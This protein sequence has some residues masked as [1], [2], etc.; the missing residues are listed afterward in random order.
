MQQNSV[1][2]L[3][4]ENVFLEDTW[5]PTVNYCLS[6]IFDV[7]SANLYHLFLNVSWQTETGEKYRQIL[8]PLNL[9]LIKLRLFLLQ[10][11]SINFNSV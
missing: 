2:F 5:E 3:L 9:C 11:E 8:S 6:V 7:L 4:Y 10:Q 1:F